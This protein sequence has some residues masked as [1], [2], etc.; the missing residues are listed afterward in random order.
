LDEKSPAADRALTYEAN[1]FVSAALIA[2]REFIR[3]F[4]AIEG[5]MFWVGSNTREA[6]DESHDAACEGKSEHC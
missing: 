6:P 5:G 2:L 4:V 1:G 3:A